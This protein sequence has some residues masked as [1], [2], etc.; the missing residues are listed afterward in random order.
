MKDPRVVPDPPQFDSRSTL[1]AATSDPA[2]AELRRALHV[3]A[4]D[5]ALR[6]DVSG[7]LARTDTL[8]GMLQA[9][10]DALVRHVDV[11]F[12]RIWTS[13]RG[14]DFLELQAS[15]GLHTNIDGAHARIRVG[16]LKIGMIAQERA[17]HLTN[18]V[19]SDARVHDKEW[20]RREGLVAFAGYPLL[21][22]ERVVGVMA[23][24]ARDLLL[25]DTLETLASIASLIAHGIERKRSEDR[26][27]RS[28]A[29]L[30]EGQR[31][32]H[33][34]SWAW[35]LDTGERFWSLEVYRI[36]GFEPA[37]TPPPLEAVLLRVHPDDAA[38]VRFT[39]A[40]ALRTHSEFRF[41][42]RV[43]IDGQTLKHVETIGH[44]VRGEDGRVVEFIGTD[45]DITERQRANQRLRR[46]I[47][48]R[49]AAV[50]AERTRIARDMHDGLLQDVTGISLQLAAL[51]PQVR[52]SS[53]A[54]AERLASILELTQR[55]SRE[56]RQAVVDMRS[57]RGDGD[58]VSAVESLSR[59]MA[60]DAALS[61]SVS[62]RGRTRPVPS[63]TRDAVVAI[64]QEA[65]TNVVK[66]AG[67]RAVA[68]GLA[69]TRARIRL[70]VRDDGCGL[71][72]APQPDGAHFGLM[73]MRER[74][75]EVGAAFRLRSKPGDGTM[76]CVDLP[77]HAGE[78]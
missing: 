18:H 11:A 5:S 10:A 72:L 36:Y 22:E 31:L 61:L 52:A 21:I 37:D 71:P 38:Q 24:F 69:F 41:Q 43:L 17:P 53:D 29:Y 63:E 25:P 75:T 3:R 28:E 39:V 16:E 12:A 1:T 35:R 55:T 77:I 66:H 54:A 7:A 34:G 9:C 64:V 2:S 47:R 56:A 23:M 26:L 58:L 50:L 40:E 44:P 13:N 33:T 51:L 27:R 60:A 8:R 76:I 6:A 48:A 14:G 73:G 45:M 4:R 20:A 67:A 46:A 57:A 78:G 70:T 62:V 68:I 19:L 65:L 59:K 49:Y 74:A 15:A 32:S 30:A 42:T